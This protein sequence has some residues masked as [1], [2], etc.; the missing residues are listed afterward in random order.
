[1]EGNV[2]KQEQLSLEFLLR[3]VLCLEIVIIPRF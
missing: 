1:M 3:C 2:E